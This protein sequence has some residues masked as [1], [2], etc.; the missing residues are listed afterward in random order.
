[1]LALKNINRRL[2]SY[3]TTTLILSRFKRFLAGHTVQML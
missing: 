3:E 2:K 1:M